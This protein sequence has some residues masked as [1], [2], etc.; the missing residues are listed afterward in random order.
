[1]EDVKHTV[2]EMLINTFYTE[3]FNCVESE[4]I[5]DEINYNSYF[6]Y[7]DDAYK[8][9]EKNF[10]DAFQA[11]SY[12]KNIEEEYGCKIADYSQP[13]DVA[14]KILDYY[15]HDIINQLEFLFDGT[16]EYFTT[17]TAHKTINELSK[18]G[19]LDVSSMNLVL[20]KNQASINNLI[21]IFTN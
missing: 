2:L 14:N 13:V 1:M 4:Y 15:A 11:L 21:E 20:D 17:Y 6:I 5:L 16:H 12:L 10:E 19:D 8:F 7:Y 18:L 9:L 3:D